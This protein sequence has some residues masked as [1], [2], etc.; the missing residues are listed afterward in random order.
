MMRRRSSGE[1]RRHAQ[2][3]S[4][5]R[6]HPLHKPVAASTLQMPVHG[7][8]MLMTLEPMLS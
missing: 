3:S 4:M 6:A 1:N 5:V 8:S 2:I 7:V